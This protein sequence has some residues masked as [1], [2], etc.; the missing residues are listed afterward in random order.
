MLLPFASD[1]MEGAHPDVM[2][3]LIETNLVSCPGYGSDPFSEEARNKIRLAC[4]APNAG[5]WFLGGGTQTNALTIRSLLRPWQG[6]IAAD[7]GH[8]SLHEAGAVEAGGHKVMTLPGKEGKLDAESVQAFC[9]AFF[10]DENRDHM[11]APGMVYISFP[12][13]YGTLY[14]LRELEALKA[15]CDR[16]S[17]Y[18][19]ADGA[20]LAYALAA[21]ENDV[22][23]PDLARLCHAF[24]I[25][26]TK[27]GT[28]FGEA[29]VVP[30]P[31]VLPHFFTLIK[32]N[33]A[34]F[35]K[36][37]VAGVQFGALF[38]DD[39]YLKI[40]ENGVRQAGRIRAALD[41]FGILQPI[42]SPTNQ[43][44]AVFTDR[45]LKKLAE[46]VSYSYWEPYGN[47]RS[48]VRLAAS[49]ATESET[50][51]KLTEVLQTVSQKGETDGRTQ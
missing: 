31:S 38:T 17:L 26:G 7:T 11:T 14:S 12:T 6:V 42:R 39:L 47:G 46:S 20:R 51:H 9:E 8:I 44:F 28:L 41:A 29:L 18:L 16:Y 24:Y 50:V 34:L 19:Y 48:V 45:Q 10:A 30:D 3:A 23:L 32:Q 13:E 27:C 4:K 49:W 40:G 43:V 25:G 22:T 33:G 37:K 15:V 1:Y 2:Q 5:V 35:A 21:K 36:G